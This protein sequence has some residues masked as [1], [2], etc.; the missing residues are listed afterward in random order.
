[1]STGSF[2][3][4]S[5]QPAASTPP[6]TA[7]PVSSGESNGFSTLYQDTLSSSQS[8]Q[9]DT[10]AA[11]EKPAAHGEDSAKAHSS[12][13]AESTATAA[14][15]A[16]TLRRDKTPSTSDAET[17]VTQ[18]SRRRTVQADDVDDEAANDILASMALEQM[19]A[20]EPQDPAQKTLTA[21]TA[22]T[23]KGIEAATVAVT[24]ADKQAAQTND[25]RND[26]LQQALALQ[27]LVDQKRTEQ[28]STISNSETLKAAAQNSAA[29]EGALKIPAS[30]I[31]QPLDSATSS[32]RTRARTTPL[33]TSQT[34]TTAVNQTALSTAQQ[35]DEQ[36]D[37]DATSSR[38]QA[39]F[40]LQN[41][42]SQVNNNSSNG[43]Q[44]A[45][46]ATLPAIDSEHWNQAL[47]SHISTMSRMDQGQTTLTLAPASLG[48]LEVSL[49]MDRGQADIQFVTHSRQARDALTSSV[50]A[51]HHALADQGIQVQN[52]SVV[53]HNPDAGQQTSQQQHAFS[54]MTSDQQ[55]QQS[56]YQ[57]HEQTSTPETTANAGQEE[58]VDTLSVSDTSTS[59]TQGLRATA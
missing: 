11:A 28:T 15:N 37:V 31:G 58:T 52:V 49:Q 9:K 5:V 3:I 7:A 39:D 41:A 54:G 22:A 26:A 38:S 24:T 4:T 25:A 16:S 53:E 6:S 36:Y 18:T 45:S 43:T 59:T 17:T 40:G 8:A 32:D 13:T 55:S 19:R 56:S 46:A 21:T 12:A 1:M 42:L 48:S 33:T 20:N 27:Q 50:N 34:A 23:T 51:L 44:A 2:S 35:A 57:A 10:D 14:L 30:T 47:A 29:Q